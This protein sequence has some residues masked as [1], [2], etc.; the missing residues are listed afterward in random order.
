MFNQAVAV[1]GRFAGVCLLLLLQACA[2]LQEGGSDA[3]VLEDGTVFT[4]FETEKPEVQK[5]L[6]AQFR[7]WRGTPYKLGGNSKAGIDCSAFVQQTLA[8]HFNVAAPRSTTQQVNMGV[9]VGRDA[10]QVGDLVFFRT[11]HTTQHVGFYLGDGKLLHAS[12]KVGVT[13]SRLDDLYWR[14]T[15]WKVRRVM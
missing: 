10:M 11:G 15:F 12:T 8:T 6:L 5:A 9:D 7:E 13:I 4:G 14:K 3:L 2:G 1:F